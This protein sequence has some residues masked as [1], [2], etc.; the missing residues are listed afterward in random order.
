MHPEFFG[1]DSMDGVGSLRCSNIPCMLTNGFGRGD[2]F[3]DVSKLETNMIFCK[4]PE[5]H[6]SASAGGETNMIFWGEP[7]NTHWGAKFVLAFWMHQPLCK[8]LR[9]ARPLRSTPPKGSRGPLF[10]RGVISFDGAALV[11]A[12]RRLW[13]DRPG[14][15]TVSSVRGVLVVSTRRT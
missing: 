10:G 8:Q 12:L 1:R 5:K 3:V 6:S 13:Q 7:E 15:P 14:L 9:P 11:C 4:K 2:D